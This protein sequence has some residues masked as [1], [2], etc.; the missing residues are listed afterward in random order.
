MNE[1]NIEPKVVIVIPV[2]NW[3]SLKKEGKR[4]LDLCMKSLLK[5]KYKN[6][7]IV[8][9]DDASTDS[10]IDYIT[11]NY[12]YVSIVKNKTNGGFCKNSNS[13]IKYAIK[14]FKPKY[15]VLLNDDVIIVDSYWLKKMVK[16]AEENSNVGA[17]GCKLNYPN[18]R[19]QS[20]KYTVR[21]VPRY[22]GRS[23]LDNSQFDYVSESEGVNGAL[24]L[25][26]AEVFKKIGYL[27]ENFYMGFDDADLS[28]RLKS[29]GYK[30]FYTGLTHAI[31][32][33]G[34]STTSQI[35]DKRFYLVNVGFAYLAFKHYN[36]L[37]RIIAFSYILGGSIFSIDQP[38][39]K[40][41]IFTLHIRDRILWRFYVSI[42]AI[43][44]GYKLCIKSKK[45]E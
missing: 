30:I 29:S 18:G 35:S 6:Y 10:T 45:S 1:A 40:R 43:I 25:I 19:I 14:K 13:G 36:L 41:S 28:I 4:L 33:E 2:Y 37:E 5:T 22:V 15:I 16:I 27:D 9:S 31:H 42:K 21:P 39:K 32:F 24:A 7:N 12:P 38:N 8:V 3:L 44:E 23:E 17:V 26:K 20:T 11:K 34:S